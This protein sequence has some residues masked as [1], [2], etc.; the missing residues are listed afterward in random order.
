M[1]SLISGLPTFIFPPNEF[2]V[3]PNFAVVMLL[4]SL[5]SITVVCIITKSTGGQN[6][7]IKT[8]VII[9]WIY[10]SS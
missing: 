2:L 7:K 1:T 3:A 8:K 4:C 5:L 10:L 9:N 6:D